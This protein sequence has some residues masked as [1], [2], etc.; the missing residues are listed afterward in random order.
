APVRPTAIILYGDPVPVKPRLSWRISTFCLPT[1]FLNAG[2]FPAPAFW[3]YSTARGEI[4][5]GDPGK[6]YT[7][8][9]ERI[10]I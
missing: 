9:P 8:T 7:F 6:W 1:A 10:L 4:S 3:V 5:P 2:T